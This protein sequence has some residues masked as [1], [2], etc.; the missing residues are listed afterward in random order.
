M[1]PVRLTKD[2]AEYVLTSGDET[3]AFKTNFR[4]RLLKPPARHG[5]DGVVQGAGA[6]G[7]EMFYYCVTRCVTISAV[8]L[9]RR[10]LSAPLPRLFSRGVVSYHLL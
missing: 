9:S 10:A 6:A 1:G 4:V 7:D 8:S 5:N 2:G 3:S